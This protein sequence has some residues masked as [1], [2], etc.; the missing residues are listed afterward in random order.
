M[1]S[2]EPGELLSVPS[3]EN[4]GSANEVDPNLVGTPS[5]PISR[6]YW[7]S[8]NVLSDEIAIRSEHLY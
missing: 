6:R 5:L 3:L 7:I 4:D 2:P 1:G 8:S